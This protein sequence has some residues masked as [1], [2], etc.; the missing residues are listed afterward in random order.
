MKKFAVLVLIICF[1]AT[2]A[3]AESPSLLIS[4]FQTGSEILGE[5]P[6][7]CAENEYDAG[8]LEFVEI[9]NPNNLPI[10]LSSL[11]L[12][13]EFITESG[14]TTRLFA[15]LTGQ[16]KENG[17]FLIS[18]KCYLQDKANMFFNGTFTKDIFPKTSG[19][20]LRLKTGGG[21]VLDQVSW[22]KAAPSA[23]WWHE[24][25]II[26]HDISINRN[27]SDGTFSAPISPTTP[28]EAFQPD[29][30]VEDPPQNEDPN[31]ELPAQNCQHLAITEIL[32]NPEGIDTDKEFIEIFNPT[33]QELSLL[34]C[35]LKVGTKQ[36]ALPDELLLPGHYKA[37]YSLQTKL[38]LANSS[39]TTI[40]L[41][42]N[43]SEQG[44]E[45]PADLE[46]DTAWALFEDSWQ[47][48]Q[49]LTP[50]SENV[51]VTAEKKVQSTSTTS[52]T[53]CEA[54]K[55]LNPATN[56]CRTI[57]APLALAP[58]K[59]G[60]ERNIETNRCRSIELAGAEPKP[61]E[62]GQER[63]PETNRCRKILPASTNLPQ[64]TEMESPQKQNPF[65]YWAI[66]LLVAG[67]L[68]YAIFEWRHNIFRFFEKLKTKG[69][70]L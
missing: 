54:A 40:W 21:E 5:R 62:E 58:C 12:K 52:S 46:S 1:Y 42:S 61:C 68:G 44:V 66:G 24:P 17:Y 7:N 50:S 8:K 43:E 57:Q 3:K 9:Y 48:T 49:Q 39:P 69:G 41:I 59:P 36:F 32:P 10:D 19:G 67:G 14:S 29:P 18:Y 34:G 70:K 16:I 47:K 6:T 33:N 63:N 20:Y 60:Q 55:E 26:G 64:I 11:G 28:G 65:G 37:F 15:N 4:E 22:G 25:K 2:S 27:F 31:P 23:N 45:Y 51:L 38:S 35:T 13:L 56:R 30:V 53:V